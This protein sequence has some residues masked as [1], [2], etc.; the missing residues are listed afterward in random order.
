MT[1]LTKWNII[2]KDIILSAL[3]VKNLPANEGDS[4]D[5]GSIPDSGRSSGQG[6]GNPLHY[7]CLGKSQWTEETD[8][9]QSMGSQNSDTIEQLNT[10][11]HRTYC[12]ITLW[13]TT[14]KSVQ[15]SHSIQ[16]SHSVMS[17][18][19]CPHGLQHA[20]PPCPSSTP[21]DCSNSCPS[22]R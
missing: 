1:C 16:F 12:I 21:G 15:F 8:G 20:R 22:S 3:V 14:E 13:I 10:V 11:Q 2:I 19:L 4:T 5:M 6:N 9:L 7:S 18:S 17:D